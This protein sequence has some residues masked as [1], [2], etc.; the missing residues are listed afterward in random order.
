ML[1]FISK[2]FKRF[3]DNIHAVTETNLTVEKK[4]IPS[5][6]WFNYLTN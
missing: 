5:I 4:P 6:P 1:L 2:C 3:M